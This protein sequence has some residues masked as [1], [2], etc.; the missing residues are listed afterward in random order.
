VISSWKKIPGKFRYL[1]LQIVDRNRITDWFHNNVWKY[2]RNADSNDYNYLCSVL[3]QNMDNPN[4][5]VKLLVH[6]L[7][8]SIIFVGILVILLGTTNFVVELWKFLALNILDKK[9]RYFIDIGAVV[10]LQC[11]QILM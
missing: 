6:K 3:M 7:G 8:E 10:C 2:N 9:H 5:I 11:L 1:E 4:N